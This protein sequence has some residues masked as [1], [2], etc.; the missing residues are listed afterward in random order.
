MGL[1]YEPSQLSAEV[2]KELNQKL[3]FMRHNINNN[4]ALIVAAVELLKRKPE[5]APRYLES[6]AQQPDRILE[7]MRKFSEEFEKTLRIT[8]NNSDSEE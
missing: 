8:R 7:E 2:I 5:M 3:S 6:L 4:L 1:S